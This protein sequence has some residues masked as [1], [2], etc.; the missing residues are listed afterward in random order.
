MLKS[1]ERREVGGETMSQS[2]DPQWYLIRTKPAK[3][4]WVRDQLVGVLPEVFLP[5]LR[6]RMPRWGKLGWSVLPLFPSYL[7][8]RCDLRGRYFDIK[9]SAGVAGLVSAGNEPLT[10][11]P[12]IVASIRARA[13]DGVV[14]IAV[15]RF[16]AG[17][18][19]QVTAGPFCGIEAVFERYLSGEE[20]VA[21]LLNAA[22]AGALRMVL[23]SGAIAREA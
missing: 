15:P 5:F 10:V 22:G 7:F 21:I 11:A 23:S 19:V 12:E 9:Y 18:R 20:R 17:E 16:A 6:A 4:R 14:E 3:E 2:S 8:A 1:A 13:I